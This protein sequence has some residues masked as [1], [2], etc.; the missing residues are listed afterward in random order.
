MGLG[1]FGMPH[2]LLRFMAIEKP[3]KVRLSRRIASIWVVIAMGVAIFIGIIG[4]RLTA[5]GTIGNLQTSADS[6]TVVIRIAT[7]LS[8][9][10]IAAAIIAGLIFAGI[11]ACTMS[12]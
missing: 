1:Y 4:N 3:E 10:S 6:E 5:N 8:K 11:L 2:I 9:H 7:E 12:T